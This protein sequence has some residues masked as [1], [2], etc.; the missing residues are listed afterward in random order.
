M[1]PRLMLALPLC[2]QL[3]A[4]ANAAP[5]AASSA[6]P[7]PALSA[8]PDHAS[9]IYRV[10][11]TVGWS[12]RRTQDAGTTVYHYVVRENALEM[13]TEGELRFA[14]GSARIEVPAREP[15]M[16]YVEVTEAGRVAPPL[17][18]GAAVAP[19]Q[20]LPSVPEP[21]DFDTFWRAGITQLEAVP[22][23]PVLTAADAGRPDVDYATLFMNTIDGAH[24]HGQI[25]RPHQEGRYPALL[26]LQWAGGPYPL[27]KQW[28][29]DRAAE[30]WLALNVEPHDVLPDQ[31]QSYYDA[32]PDE[33]KNYQAIGRDDR[34][35]NY[36]RRMYLSDYRAVEYL[37]SR[38][39]WDGHTLVV[40][41]TSMGGQQSLCTAALN[42]RVTAV[43]VNE[44]SGAD[45][46]GVLH[47]RLSG[48]PNWP[49]N[50]PQALRTA[51]YFDTVNCAAR[52][53]APALVALGFIDPIAPP[54]GIWTAFNRIP[55]RKEAVPMVDSSHNNLA[56]AEQQ[57]PWSER[58]ARWLE[59]LRR[60]GVPPTL[61]VE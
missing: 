18:L 15:A 9:G 33:L 16:I 23:A 22:V 55:G 41:G 50:D 58:S 8:V 17:S 1:L 21:V 12:V 5:D 36:F 40:M 19:A 38:P 27:Q 59:S 56:T 44:P 49:S 42:P 39:D 57:R 14:G 53:R 24:I 2:V 34:D 60:T 43:L 30:G 26:I 6:P 45:S 11:E 52:L 35:H 13:L 28:V 46:N 54:A 32:L 29:T 3:S 61:T 37:A 20:L 47:G 4:G 25:A 7:P 31:P 51:L 48:Y 10:G